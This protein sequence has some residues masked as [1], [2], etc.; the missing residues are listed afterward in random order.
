MGN[1]WFKLKYNL[2]AALKGHFSSILSFGGAFSNHIAASAK[3]CNLLKIP[4]IGII[5]GEEP[6]TWNPTLIRAR[7]EGMQAHFLSRFQYS[8]REQPYFL[9]YLREEWGNFYLIPEGGHNKLGVKGCEEILEPAS[10]LDSN[11]G[12]S[13]IKREHLVQ[14]SHICC[15]VGTGTTLAGIINSAAPHQ[16]IMGFGAMKNTGNLHDQICRFIRPGNRNK[17][18]LWEEDHFGGFGRSKPELIRF[19]EKFF[20]NS[21]IPLDFIYTGKMMFRIQKMILDDYFPQGSRVLVIHT[22]GLQGNPL[23]VSEKLGYDSN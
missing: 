14:Y 5:R 20:S 7:K 1:K 22:G 4:F 13:S 19:M 15:A 3:A 10:W 23:M 8:Q 16:E 11:Q 9:E 21:G 18:S 2:E 17:Y 6:S 12:D